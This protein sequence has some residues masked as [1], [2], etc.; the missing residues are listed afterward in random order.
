MLVHKWGTEDLFH[1]RVDMR[2]LFL[3]GFV[4][5]GVIFRLLPCSFKYGGDAGQT[6]VS[7]HSELVFTVLIKPSLFLS[8]RERPGHCFNT[9]QDNMERVNHMTHIITFLLCC[10]IVL[11]IQHNNIE[12]KRVKNISFLLYYI[13]VLQI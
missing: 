10:I 7:L 5:S 8:E 6:R 11:Q 9:L 4:F 13:T 12:S 1:L 3:D 2:R